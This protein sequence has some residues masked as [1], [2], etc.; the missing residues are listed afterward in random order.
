MLGTTM[1]TPMY[2]IYG[3]QM[4]FSVLTTTVIYAAYAGGVLVALLAF[5]RWSDAIGR[6]PLLLGGVVAALVS[7]GVF[8]A[9]DS[10]PLLLV[11]RVLSG[12]SAGVFTGTATAAVI[13]S[14]PEHW[15]GRAAAVATV[16]NIGGLGAGPVLAGILV[17]YAPHPLHLSFIVHIALA[18]FAG[19]AVLL[20]PETSPRAGRISVQRLSVP[21]QVRS[22]FV[23]ASLAG[24][25]GFAVT[26]LFAA[27]AP[28]FVVDVVGIDNQALAGAIAGSIF[29]ASAVTQVAANR[30]A[31]QNAV[32]IGCAILVVGMVILAAALQL[33]SLA[34]LIAAAV[35]A[36]VGQ[37]LTFSRGLAAVSERTPADRRAEVNSTYFV[38]VYVA[39]SL[40]VI[41]EGL[42]AEHW[43]LRTA[44][45][46]FAVA[47][48]VLAAGCL[49]A[50]LARAKRAAPA[51]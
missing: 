27:V 15:R 8:L 34:G 29:L 4:N 46:T 24:F 49:V 45:V 14:A 3:E 51:G 20:V 1:P 48:A 28:S 42:A 39:I 2:A 44:G 31:A 21:A 9:A 47:V 10:V 30:M 35:V 32:A 19:A 43:G 26:G 23:V 25:A 5:G 33:S 41:G 36:G 50:I 16:A 18:A 37:G 40:P 12:L 17:Q 13:E 22:V 6:R 38:I 7:A 11:A